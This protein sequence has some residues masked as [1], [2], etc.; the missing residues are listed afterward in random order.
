MPV[1]NYHKRRPQ[2][3]LS[4][5]IYCGCCGAKYNIAMRDY[6]RCSAKANSGLCAD[7]RTI[8]MCTVERR[9]LTAVQKHLLTSELVATAD[10][11]FLEDFAKSHG[12]RDAT[13]AKLGREH[14]DADRKLSRLLRMVED[15]HAD[16][17]AAGP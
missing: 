1:R 3:L 14:A 8:R 2:R 12:D 7:S 13:R 16:P 4:G 11:A 15:G 17:A 5:L 9:V 6:M 10:R